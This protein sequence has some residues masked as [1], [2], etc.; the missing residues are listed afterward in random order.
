MESLLMNDRGDSIDLRPTSRRSSSRSL[1][2]C[3]SEN[4][5]TKGSIVSWLAAN[6]SRLIDIQ[7]GMSLRMSQ[8]D[9]GSNFEIDPQRQASQQAD[10]TAD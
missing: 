8:Q 9:A 10:A 2:S 3:R 7:F 6:T 5:F 4:K 1:T